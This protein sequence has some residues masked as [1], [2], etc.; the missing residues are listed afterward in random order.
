MFGGPD[1]GSVCGERLACRL[2]CVAS[3]GS[4]N[5]VLGSPGPDYALLGS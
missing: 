2:L 1:L 4:E 5:A 3:D